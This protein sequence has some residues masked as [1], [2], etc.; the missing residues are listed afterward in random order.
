[1]TKT[2]LK[3]AALSGGA[4]L[5][6]SLAAGSAA[7]QEFDLRLA[8]VVNA[9]HPWIDMA[10][11]F[12]EEIAER[13][14]GAVAV[15]VFPGGSLGDDATAIDEMRVGTVDFTI[16]GTQN[17]APFVPEYQIFGL[18]Y[19]F[20]GMDHFRKATDPDGPVFAY[21][22]EAYEDHGVNLKLLALS[23]GGVRNLSNARG[24]IESPDDLD[25]VRMRVPG[26]PLESTLWS[27]QGAVTSSLPWTDL[28]QAV[29]TGL[30]EA[31]E[32]TI[33]GYYGANLHEVA[34]YH[35]VTQ[36]QIMMT[37][38]SM[39][40][41][42]WNRLPEEYR[43]IIAE[44]AQ[45]AGELG[46]A[47]GEEYDESLLVSLVEDFGV[48]VTEVDRQAFIDNVVDLHEEYAEDLGV[49]DLLETIRNL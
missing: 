34:P 25:G 29:Q 40:E 14:D 8:T 24:E 30:V 2:T 23:G 48:T 13:T 28:Y 5:G 15:S 19:L 39:S 11:F 31:F 20:E 43:Q 36:H 10:E 33:S 1:M 38:F 27:A 47:K 49:S 6:L 45:E 3:I 7:A 46:T 26:S 9:P 32:S 42:T 17:A 18:S 41:P 4:A 44:V 37:H 12:A 16:G 35:S 21:F 22:E